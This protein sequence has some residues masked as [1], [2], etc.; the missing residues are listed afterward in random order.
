MELKVKKLHPA[1][2]LPSYAHVSDAGMDLYVCEAIE[3]VSGQRV[4]I[5]TGI[6]LAI[7]TGYVGLIWDKSGLS[8]KS[9]LKTLGG[10]IDADYRGEIM[11]GMINTSADT[12]TFAVGDKVAQLLVQKIEHPTLVEVFEMESTARDSGAFGSTGK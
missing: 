5:R 8:H 6:A 3:V 7:P 10:V 11:V 1:A 12:Y 4:Q 2:K 9:G